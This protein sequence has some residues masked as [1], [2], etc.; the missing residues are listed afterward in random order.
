MY[1]HLD[2]VRTRIAA[3]LIVGAAVVAACGASGSPAKSPTG[4]AAPPTFQVTIAQDPALGAHLVGEN[5]RTL[6]V[7]TKDQP[8][9]S[10]CTGGCATNWPPFTIDAASTVQGAAGVS[11]VFATIPRDDG[12][13][14]VTFGG[15]PLYY[16][17]GDAA[18]GDVNGQGSGGVWFVVSPSGG[19]VTG[20]GGSPAPTRDSN[21]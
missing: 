21:Y 15:A 17:A 9:V 18:A 12:T 16:F 1:R 20:D 3:L 19:P 2:I 14:Q 13:H 4:T 8:G 6:Y 11:G 5:G 7:L 10:T